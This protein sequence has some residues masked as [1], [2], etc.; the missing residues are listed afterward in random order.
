GAGG[1]GQRVIARPTLAFAL[2]RRASPSA[3]SGVG[4]GR[5][6]PSRGGWGRTSP[7]RCSQ[8]GYE[9]ADR[10]VLLDVPEHDGIRHLDQL[11]EAPPHRRRI[12]P[13]PPGDVDHVLRGADLDLL[14]YLPTRLQGGGERPL[15]PQLLELG[16]AGP[17]PP[18][19]VAPCRG[20]DIERR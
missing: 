5:P 2:T 3:A 8:A 1:R 11:L 10:S 18:G 15:A 9:I 6:P 7:P 19:L 20:R 4:P 14:R 13:H 12:F 17:A 16:I